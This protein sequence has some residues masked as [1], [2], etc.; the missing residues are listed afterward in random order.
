[1]CEKPEPWCRYNLV[2]RIRWVV[3]KAVLIAV[4]GVDKPAAVMEAVVVGPE[5]VLVVVQVVVI[6]GAMVEMAAMA[7]M[8]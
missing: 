8:A 7:A 3:G 2:T 4:V 6:V 1:M 5:K